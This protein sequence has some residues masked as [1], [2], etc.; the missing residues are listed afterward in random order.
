MTVSEH[1]DGY[2]L[3]F[4]SSETKPLAFIAGSALSVGQFRADIQRLMARI[5]GPGDLLISCPGRYACGVGLLASWLSGKAVVLP[6]NHLAETLQDMR[7]RFEIVFECDAYWAQQSANAD[8]GREHHDWELQL[9]ADLQAVKLFTSGSSGTPKVI[10]KTVANLLAEAHAIAA[11]FDWPA[12]PMVAG[13]PAQHLY[14]LTFS[15]LLPW[16]LGN[17]WIDD[18]PHY[19]RD[20]LQV[21]QQVDGRTLISVPAQ[22]QAMLEDGIE[23]RDI[24]CVSAAAPLPEQLARR[25]HQQHGHDILEIYGSTETGVVGHRR[26]LSSGLWQAFPQ[27]SLSADK[28]RLRVES[29]FVSDTFPGGFLTADQVTLMSQQRFELL[30]RT[31]TIVKI[32]GKRVSLTNIEK[33]IRACPG[34]AEAAVIAVPAKGVIRDLAIWAAVV[35]DGN[36]TLS[37]RQLQTALRGKLDSIEIPRR[38]LVVKQLPRTASGKLPVSAVTSLFHEHDRCSRVQL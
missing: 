10:T 22:Y 34:V 38:I 27:V 15:I 12:G 32:A 7:G 36:C 3:R 20:V 17:A 13:V 2:S 31:D 5:Q 9:P 19:P 30:G 16:V 11:E 28:D 33:N 37:S 29:P 26:Q 25:W 18:L 24:L 4:S 8:H 14:G 23:L 6:P 1:P 21:L 35:A